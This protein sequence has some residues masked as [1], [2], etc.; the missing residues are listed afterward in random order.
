MSYVIIFD[1]VAH[2][3]TMI[4]WILVVRKKVELVNKIV[5][6]TPKFIKVIVVHMMPLEDSNV[7]NPQTNELVSP[8]WNIGSSWTSLIKLWRATVSGMKCRPRGAN[9]M[10]PKRYWGFSNHHVNP[11][12]IRKKLCS[13]EVR[14][15][16]W[17]QGRTRGCPRQERWV[18]IITDMMCYLC[19]DPSLFGLEKIFRNNVQP[20]L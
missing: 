2:I 12:I 18:Y 8:S 9:G 1:N 3:H 14:P 11:V 16:P 17:S 7:L 5:F 19:T 4:C 13:R 10:S 6:A 20:C 15:L